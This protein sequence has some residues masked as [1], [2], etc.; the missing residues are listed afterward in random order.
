MNNILVID[1]N[2]DITAMLEAVLSSDT[3]HVQTAENGLA[4]L[5]LLRE[6]P[7]DV[8]ITDIIMPE[9]NGFEVIS[10]ANGMQP[11]PQVIAMTGGPLC[12]SRESRPEVASALRV[13]RV[14]YKPFTINELLESLHLP[15]G[16]VGA[17]A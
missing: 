13:Q 9:V 6:R 12:V 16:C 1:D 14:L 8:V 4:G 3:C 7:F 5:Q 17:V 11:R 2:E 15:D 10:E